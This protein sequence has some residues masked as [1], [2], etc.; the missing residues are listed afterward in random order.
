[1]L[2]QLLLGIMIM[3]KWF[4]HVAS[5]QVNVY[6]QL[7][8]HNIALVS[9]WCMCIWGCVFPTLD[10]THGCPLCCASASV[11]IVNIFIPILWVTPDVCRNRMHKCL[12]APKDP[13]YV[14]YVLFMGIL[15]L[16]CFDRPRKR[17]HIFTHTT[18]RVVSCADACCLLCLSKTR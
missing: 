16:A 8:T 10:Q 3:F 13:L 18:M 1:M 4:E 11:F 14:S 9:V 17:A 12:E 2:V 5:M 6:L 7:V 15:V